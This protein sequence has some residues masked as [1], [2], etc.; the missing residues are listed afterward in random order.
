MNIDELKL[1]LSTVH[2]AGQGAQNAFVWYILYEVLSDLIPMVTLLTIV[3]VLVR[4]A[5]WWITKLSEV[6]AKNQIYNNL[7]NALEYRYDLDRQMKERLF[8]TIRKHKVFI[9]GE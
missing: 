8:E 9:L 4:L 1:I 2:D 5:K 6:E 7:V 3:L